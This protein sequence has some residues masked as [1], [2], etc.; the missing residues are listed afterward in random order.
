M[1]SQFLKDIL[2]W[3]KPVLAICIHCDNLA[4]IPRAQNFIHNGKFSYILRRHNTVKQ[5]LSNGI[6][7]IDFISSKDNLADPFTK[8]LSGV[9]INCILM[10]MGVKA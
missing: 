9:R 2:L 6:I 8:N 7:F 4:M 5:L 10:G 3:P 1:A